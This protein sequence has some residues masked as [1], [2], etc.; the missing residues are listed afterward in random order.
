[1]LDLW[2]AGRA[3]GCAPA[4]RAPGRWLA[5]HAGTQQQV[6]AL[7]LVLGPAAY[8]AYCAL[9]A[10]ATTAAAATA[11]S[12]ATGAAVAAIDAAADRGRT[13]AEETRALDA[14][15]GR[16]ARR[17]PHQDASAVAPSFAAIYSSLATIPY[18][19]I[20]ALS[21]LISPCPVCRAAARHA[22]AAARG[23]ATASLHLPFPTI[24]PRQ[25]KPA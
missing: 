21:P 25:R 17:T 15:G 23:R 2:Q 18:T 13:R 3:G 10:A 24:P 19:I 7:L 22:L 5:Q 8:V 1:M 16:F 11:A 20:P 14:H 6:G 9:V 12:A 4:H